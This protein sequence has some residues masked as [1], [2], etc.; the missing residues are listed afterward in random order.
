[1]HVNPPLTRL[2]HPSSPASSRPPLPPL[3]PSAPL[4]LP[5]SNPPPPPVQERETQKK[6]EE[7]RKAA[8]A[9]IEET[10]KSTLAVLRDGPR[11][12]RASD[13]LPADGVLVGG[14]GFVQLG[15]WRI[16]SADDQHFVIIHKD[17]VEEENRVA[18]CVALRVACSGVGCLRSV[19]CL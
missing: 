18:C 19:C 15:R 6:H 8:A 1:M 14:D 17:K 12:F 10:K 11:L 13:N 7:A 16:G 5:L 4:S 9:K 2:S 3:L